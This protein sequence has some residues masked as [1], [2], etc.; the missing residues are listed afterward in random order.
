MGGSSNG[1]GVR[2]SASCGVGPVICPKEGVDLTHCF[3][4]FTG[5]PY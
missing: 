3:F 1:V 2:P 5:C 4:I